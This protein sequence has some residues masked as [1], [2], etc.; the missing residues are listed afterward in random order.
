MEVQDGASDYIRLFHDSSG[1]I[2]KDY[3]RVSEVP[4][5]NLAKY[6]EGACAI[7]I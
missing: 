2:D 4:N 6:Y 1:H 3:R 5:C 7:F